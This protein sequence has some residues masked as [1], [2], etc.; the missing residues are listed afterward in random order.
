MRR[1]IAL[2]TAEV[3]I[4]RRALKIYSREFER[5][6]REMSTGK[7]W[8]RDQLAGLVRGADALCDRLLR[9][10]FASDERTVQVLRKDPDRIKRVVRES[11][12]ALCDL[13]DAGVVAEEFG[14]L[15]ALAHDLSSIDESIR[16]ERRA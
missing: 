3:V 11:F 16:I 7:Q 14:E 15:G 9:E 12:S 13:R 6:R 8:E 2:R 10:T 4:L 5:L 1:L